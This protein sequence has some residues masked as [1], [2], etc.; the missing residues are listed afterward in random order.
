MLQ[1]KVL[2]LLRKVQAGAQKKVKD[3]ET[4]HRASALS[5]LIVFMEE[6]AKALP[7]RVV[8]FIT[9]FIFFQSRG[10]NNTDV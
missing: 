1:H 5:G 10:I 4:V 6:D 7:M 3:S 9:N 8:V 2:K